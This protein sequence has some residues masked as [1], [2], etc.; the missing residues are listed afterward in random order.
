MALD[1][2]FNMYKV[3]YDKLDH[4]TRTLFHSQHISTVNI[5][6][7][8]DDIY[9][10]CRNGQSNHEFQCCGNMA[11]KQLVSNVLNI[12]AH[13]REWAVRK[14]LTVKV[15]AYYTMSTIFENR[16]IRHDYRSNYISRSDITNADC[17]YVN[18]CIREA[19]PILKTVTQY[20]D[21]VYVVDTRGLEPS[22]FPHLMATE[23]SDSPADWNFL[24]TKDIVEFQ[25]AYY[26][27]FSV[28]YPKGDD[29]M[30]LDTPSTWR[31]IANKE[32]VESEYLYKYP[33]AFLPITLAIVGDKKRSIP[34]I[35][36]LSWRTMMRMMDDIIVDN[37]GLDP[38]SHA[39]KFLDSLEAKNYKMSEIQT[40]L[41]LVQPS[42]NAALAS[43]VV[44]EN[45][46]LQFIDT[47]DYNSL[48]ELN[49]SP[50]LFASCPINIRFLTRVGD[51]KP[52][53]PFK[54]NY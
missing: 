45:I 35:K 30:L 14:N 21:G 52:I 23:L 38:Y 41:N 3:K 8:L 4:L 12:I 43:D 46:R 31:H 5:F 49:R 13:Y 29:S 27:K 11:P 6:I 33:D 44:K 22:A 7:S 36:G 17:Y 10:H 2:R 53:S 16:S 39:M 42:T 37:T 51:V 34:K 25:Y 32:K 50:E 19:A 48:M 24:I 54:L 28:I 1:I 15:Y 26:D 20:I 9:W 40:N 18:N 47:P